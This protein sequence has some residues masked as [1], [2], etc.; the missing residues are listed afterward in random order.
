VLKNE[1]GG[2][3]DKHFGKKITLECVQILVVALKIPS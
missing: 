2:E 1:R 3:R